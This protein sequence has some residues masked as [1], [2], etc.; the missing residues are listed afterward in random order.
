MNTEKNCKKSTCR[1][2]K[3][4]RLKLLNH[5]FHT[6][7]AKGGKLRKFWIIIFILLSLCLYSQFTIEPQWASGKIFKIPES[8]LYDEEN[9]CLYVSNIN[10]NPGEKDGNGFISKL[11]TDGTIIELHLIDG[12]DAPKGSAVWNGKLYV[13]D[14][15]KLVKIDISQRKMIQRIPIKGAV[16]LNDVAA[17][18]FG[19]IYISDSSGKHGA[20]YKYD[21]EE[22]SLWLG[23][24]KVKS[25]NGLFCTDDTLFIGNGGTGQIL[26]ASLRDKSIK[27]SAEV[28][29]NI[30][31]LIGLSADEFLVSDWTGTTSIVNSQN[32]K[33]VL[34][35]TTDKNINAA[36]L[37]FVPSEQLVIIPT[38]N[39]DRVIAYKLNKN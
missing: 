26:S 39:D 33:T 12:L 19:N 15:D 30:D 1:I 17:D 2:E 23:S 35:E 36:D 32:E 18:N 14:I 31:G 37:S 20:V 21:G 7:D 28:G 13:S 3:P 8:V 5:P 4:D 22:A 34:L 29:S 9:D 38:F 16:F 24:D 27:I 11:K 6:E 10:G 25:P